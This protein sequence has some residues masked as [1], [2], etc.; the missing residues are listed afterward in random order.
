MNMHRLM[1]ALLFCGAGCSQQN[2]PTIAPIKKDKDPAP[3]S[4]KKVEAGK[5][6]S[7]EFLADG[8]RRV[9][10]EGLVCLREGPLELFMC[11]GYGK[12]HESVVCAEIDARDLHKALLLAGA[13]QGS[14]VQFEP[15]YKPASGSVIKIFVRFKENGEEKTID[16]HQWVRDSKT[17]KELDK[18]WVFGGSYFFTPESDDPKAPKR[19]PLYAANGGEIV[20]VSNFTAAMM[21]LPIKSSDLNSELSFEAFAGRIPPLETK[22]TVIFEPQPDPKHGKQAEPR[23]KTKP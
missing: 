20:C 12:A 10:V 13:V 2:S 14:P 11:R 8:K 18:D 16:A 22:V 15:E 17:G 4:T 7:V 19:S 23:S 21:D 1:I 6:I 5:N 9:L 3:Q